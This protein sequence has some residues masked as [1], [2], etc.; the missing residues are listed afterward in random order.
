MYALTEIYYSL[1][2]EGCR[3]GMP[4]VFVRFAGCNLE[5]NL[6]K[7]DRSPGTFLCDTEFPPNLFLD[8]QQ[9]LDAIG[10]ADVHECKRVLLTGGE[11][12]LQV[13]TRLIATLREA[14]YEIA[15]ETNGTRQLPMGIDWVTCSPKMPDPVL[16]WADE[17]KYVIVAGQPLPESPIHSEN[18][19]ISPAWG[20]DGTLKLE[21]FEWCMKLVRENPMWRLSPQIHKIWNIR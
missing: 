20:P 5:C 10:E 11:P 16:T 4:H 15:I 18:Y 8:L 7:S 13:N 19:I 12:A 21:T 2:G 3:V 6:T 17:A 14:E 1:Q 9:L